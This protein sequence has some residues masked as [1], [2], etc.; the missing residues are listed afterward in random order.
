V[1]LADFFT[2]K[3]VFLAVSLLL[4]CNVGI[5]QRIKWQRLT[6]TKMLEIGFTGNAY[7]GD[8]GSAY[9]KWGAGASLSLLLNEKEKLNGGISLSYHS[10]SGQ[11]ISFEPFPI[12]EEDVYPNTFFRSNSIAA[13]YNLRYHFI[14]SDHIHLYLA[15]GVGLLR[16]SSK[17][18]AGNNLQD[19]LLTRNFDESY[20]STTF[21]LPTS[22]G[23]VF[24]LRNGYGLGLQASIQNVFSDYID[25]ISQ[26]GE[27]PGS[28]NIISIKAAFYVP[29]SFYS[30]RSRRR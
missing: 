8:L 26:L 18:S 20:S 29:L 15:Q 1:K 21:I 7:N 22:V 30:T 4:L 3:I 27:K 25:N 28:D 16:F 23:C 6:P 19:R 14:K 9:Q 2:M 17:D 13:S 11:T 12:N 10:F 24:L 5:S